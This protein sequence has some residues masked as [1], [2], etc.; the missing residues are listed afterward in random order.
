ME[1]DVEGIDDKQFNRGVDRGAG[2]DGVVDGVVTGVDERA[3]GGQ[4]RSGKALAIA[5]CMLKKKT[6][7]YLADV[8]AYKAR[9]SYLEST[10]TAFKIK[11]DGS[12][13]NAPFLEA[14][15]FDHAP[16]MV[17]A[18]VQAERDAAVE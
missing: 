7:E 18:S 17:H 8:A 14:E 15:E 4:H 13:S 16:P 1:L 6:Q 12:S 2:A 3:H 5:Q 9:I 10:L 11:V